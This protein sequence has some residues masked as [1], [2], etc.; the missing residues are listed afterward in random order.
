MGTYVPSPID[1]SGLELHEDLQIVAEQL[2]ENVHENWARH[3]LSE[4]WRWGPAR[5]DAERTHP[6]LLPYSELSEA[7]KQYDRLAASEMLKAIVA[8]G[9][10]IQRA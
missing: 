7:T 8:L 4:G 1:T 9:Y 6:D 2:A 3:R 5:N 10:R